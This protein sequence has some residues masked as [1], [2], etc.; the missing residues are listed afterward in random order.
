MKLLDPFAFSLLLDLLGLLCLAFWGGVLL[1][2]MFR[3]PEEGTER[4]VWG[5]F[6]GV[7]HVL[8]AAVYLVFRRPRRIRLHNQ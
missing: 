3:E 2:C 4:L 1:D 7:T 6:I 8:G 5:L